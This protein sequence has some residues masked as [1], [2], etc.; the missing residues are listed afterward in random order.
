MRKRVIG[1]E[2]DA[3]KAPEQPSD[4]IPCSKSFFPDFGAIALVAV[5]QV[6]ALQ[7]PAER[8]NDHIGSDP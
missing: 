6:T 4:E 3:G 2:E 5:G 8:V 1:K 7:E